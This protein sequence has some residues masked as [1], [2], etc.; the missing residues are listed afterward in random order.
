MDNVAMG[1]G[2]VLTIEP[3]VGTFRQQKHDLQW[4]LGGGYPRK[5]IVFQPENVFWGF[6]Q[7]DGD[8]AIFHNCDFTLGEDI[9]IGDA[10]YTDFRLSMV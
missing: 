5:R 6:V 3:G 4:Q 1:T 10:G 7:V 2:T 8:S 9:R